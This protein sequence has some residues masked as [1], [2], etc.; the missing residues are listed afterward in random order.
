MAPTLLLAC[1]MDG[2]KKGGGTQCALVCP[3]GHNSSDLTPT[4]EC[5]LDAKEGRDGH[6]ECVPEGGE[7]G[8]MAAVVAEYVLQLVKEAG[9]SQ[10]EI[11]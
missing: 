3:C 9:V 5:G 7:V 1:H 8:V 6:L 10:Q 11:A 4:D 2:W